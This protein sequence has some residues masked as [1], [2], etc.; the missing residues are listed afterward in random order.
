MEEEREGVSEKRLEGE[1]A[2]F[3]ASWFY[4]SLRLLDVQGMK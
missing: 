1:T 4:G 2:A 3:Y